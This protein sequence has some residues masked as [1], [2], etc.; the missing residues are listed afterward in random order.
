MRNFQRLVAHPVFRPV[1]AN[2]DEFEDSQIRADIV[3]NG[4]FKIASVDETG[5]SLEK[6]DTYW[7]KDK[8]KLEKVT[9]IPAKDADSALKAYRDGEV[10][11]VTN[12]DFEP[13]ALKLLTPYFDFRRTTHSALNFYEFNRRK[14]PFND[15]RVRKALA[16]A[17]ERERLT[18][19]KM[20]GATRPAYNFLPF[21]EPA[22]ESK[23]TKDSD[24]ARDLLEKAG[25]PNGENFPAVRLVVN[26]N[27]VQKQIAKSV[28]EMWRKE[29]NVET[30]IIVKERDEL[31]EVKA[32]QEYDVVRRGVVFPT[33]DETAN[34]LSIFKPAKEAGESVTSGSDYGSK[35]GKLNLPMY[36]NSNT[37]SNSTSIGNSSS[38]ESDEL[39]VEIGEKKYILTE[40]EAM[41]EVPAIPL[42]FPTS[43]SLVKPYVRGFEMNALD[44]PS[45]KE[46]NIDSEWQPK[47]PKS[48][49]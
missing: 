47:I 29:L 10:D 5:V 13:L 26:R 37:D 30:E 41:A 43:Y 9:F 27:N 28:A 18:E 2:G 15:R 23:L 4:A 46:V 39:I 49:S 14:P 40:E 21:N 22:K 45:L 42:Y 33:A 20:D 6:S 38:D 24:K 19:D 34:M 3:T 7:N 11:A 12:V 48:E 31:E 17:I 8:V 36:G 44:A 1:Y 16:I 25:F 35:S 32:L